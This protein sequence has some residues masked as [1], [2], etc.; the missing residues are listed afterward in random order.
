MKFA[1]KLEAIKHILSLED[2]AE[3]TIEQCMPEGGVDTT[4]DLVSSPEIEG[5]VVLT[6]EHA[7]V[8]FGS[9]ERDVVISETYIENV[10]FVDKFEA[11]PNACGTGVIQFE[12]RTMT[13]NMCQMDESTYVYLPTVINGVAERNTKFAVELYSGSETDRILVAK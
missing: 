1:D 2:G 7:I 9:T 13:L 11:I 4:G 8:Q 6:K 5:D 3:I 10:I 12:G